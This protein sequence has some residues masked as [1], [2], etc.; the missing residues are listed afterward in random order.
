MNFSAIIFDFDGVIFDSERFHLQAYNQIFKDYNF[1]LSYTEYLSKYIGLS[2]EPF[3]H[4]VFPEKKIAITNDKIN[5]IIARK[6]EIYLSILANSEKVE[7]LLGLVDFLYKVKKIIKNFSIC[8]GTSRQELLE[9]LNNMQPNDLKNYFDFITTI[10]DVK[11]GKPSPEGYLLTAKKLNMAPEK[12]LVIEDTQHGIE[13]AK[14]A[15]MTV[16]GLSENLNELKNANYLARNYEEIF[17]WLTEN[18][19]G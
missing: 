1:S 4:Q 11:K 17:H 13:A 15:N 8:S 5:N 16:I 14:A 2:D 19:K 3:F 10:E 6:K 7:P 18:I 9:A 12:C